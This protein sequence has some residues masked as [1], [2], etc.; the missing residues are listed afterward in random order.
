MD[1][2]LI[3]LKSEN[4]FAKWPDLV[5]IVPFTCDLTVVVFLADVDIVPGRERDQVSVFKRSVT[6]SFFVATNKDKK[7]CHDFLHFFIV[8]SEMDLIV[9]EMFYHLTGL[10]LAWNWLSFSI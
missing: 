7:M 3:F 6:N 4:V 2:E 5:H 1:G 8:T 10:A 9:L